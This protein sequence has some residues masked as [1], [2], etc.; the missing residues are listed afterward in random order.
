MKAKLVTL[1]CSA[2]LLCPTASTIAKDTNKATKK[3][4]KVKSLVESTLMREA[5]KKYNNKKNEASLKVLNVVIR[6]DSDHIA[7]L[8]YR[9]MLKKRLK[10]DNEA[11]EDFQRA[12]KAKAKSGEAIFFK[13][14]ANKALGNDKIASKLF[15]SAKKKGYTGPSC[16]N[17][18]KKDSDCK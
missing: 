15:K 6:N 7:A 4:K 3:E 9:G 18:G 17:S 1:L 16:D 12:T 14:K 5:I 2:I 11:V 8:Y 13:A 10:K